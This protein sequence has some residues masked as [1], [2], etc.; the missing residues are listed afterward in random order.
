MANKR[1]SKSAQQPDFVLKHRIAGAAFLLFFGALFL[2]WLLGPPSE[3]VKLPDQAREQA[4][5]NLDSNDIENDLLAAI[6]SEEVADQEQVY[7]SK[8][9]PLNNDDGNGDTT[10]DVNRDRNDGV[11]VAR[12]PT[13]QESSAPEDDSTQ[14]N[15]SESQSNTQEPSTQ[16]TAPA[17]AAADPEPGSNPTPSSPPSNNTIAAADKVDVGWVVQ[18]GVFTDKRGAARVVN[19]LREKGFDPS[20]TIVD[21][22]RGKATGTR[23]WLGPYAQRVNAAKAKTL[24]TSKTGEAGF[25]RAYP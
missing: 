12:A 19:D 6:E 14:S 1:K 3:A 23:I 11:E 7:I 16:E 22:N 13:S 5:E 15:N 10:D 8:I 21:T 2:P 9:T 25:I 20:T 17:V 24:L 4:S 18:V